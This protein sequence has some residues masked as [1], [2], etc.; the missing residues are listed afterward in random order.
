MV[1]NSA[2]TYRYRERVRAAIAEYTRRVKETWEVYGCPV[3]VTQDCMAAM[4]N[5]WGTLRVAWSIADKELNQ[6]REDC[7]QAEIWA[8][9]G[10]RNVD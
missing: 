3:P 6:A 5:A 2:A 7:L 9:D 10:G 4:I 1:T 8:D